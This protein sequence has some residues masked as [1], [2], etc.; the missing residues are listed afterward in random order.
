MDSILALIIVFWI[1]S[2]F[3]KALNPKKRAKQAE[4]NRTAK[5]TGGRRTNRPPPPRSMRPLPQSSR[6]PAKRPS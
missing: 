3:S 2:A 5:H 1:V 4:K 6:W